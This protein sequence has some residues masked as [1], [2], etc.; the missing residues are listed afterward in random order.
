MVLFLMPVLAR[1]PIWIGIL[2]AAIFLA[3]DIVIPEYVAYETTILAFTVFLFLVCLAV[4]DDPREGLICGLTA[5]LA[6]NAGIFAQYAVSFGSELAF[7]LLPYSLLLT[8]PYLIVGAL[9]GYLGN[10]LAGRP[11]ARRAPKSIQTRLH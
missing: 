7:V 2:V 10:R 4:I 8:S 6:Q 3:A 5:T 11:K 1:K 9:G